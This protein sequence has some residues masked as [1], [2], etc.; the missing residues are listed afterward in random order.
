M[1]SLQCVFLNELSCYPAYGKNMNML[2]TC[3]YVI[4]LDTQQRN[5]IYS[6]LEVHNSQLAAVVGKTDRNCHLAKISCIWMSK[7]KKKQTEKKLK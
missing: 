4:C 7:L 3:T 2:R 5:R 1:V 6:V